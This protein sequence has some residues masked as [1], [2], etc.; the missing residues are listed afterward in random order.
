M[1]RCLPGISIDTSLS[2]YYPIE[3]L[4]LIEFDGERYQPDGW[5]CRVSAEDKT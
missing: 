2:D 4:R 5:S 3:Q 1:P